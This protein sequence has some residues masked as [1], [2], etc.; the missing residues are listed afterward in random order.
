MYGLYVCTYTCMHAGNMCACA[1]VCTY[2][3]VCVE[4]Y[5]F[6]RACVRAGERTGMHGWVR[7]CVCVHARGSVCVCV[8]LCLCVSVSLC[9]CVSVSL[10]LC[11]SVF[12]CLCVSVSLCLCVSVPLCLCAS[13]SVCLFVHPCMSR[14]KGAIDSRITITVSPA[15]PRNPYT[16]DPNPKP[17]PLTCE[18]PKALNNSL[19]LTRPLL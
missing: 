3:R 12:L 4:A 14:C 16:P 15:L 8:C 9:L 18:L 19:A 17:K 1:H 13:V 2:V 10:C 5:A 6:V 11:V 7:G